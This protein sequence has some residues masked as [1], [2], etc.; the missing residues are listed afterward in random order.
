MRLFRRRP[1]EKPPEPRPR[2][3]LIAKILML[4]GIATVLYLFI[5]EVLMR[6]LA[7]LTPS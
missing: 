3:P 5:T 1:P 7:A 4:I 6:V 2:M